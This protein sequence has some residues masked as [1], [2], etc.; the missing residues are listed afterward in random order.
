MD[1]AGPV[2]GENRR[3]PLGPSGDDHEARETTDDARRDP[4]DHIGCDVKVI[5]RIVNG[6]TWSTGG[7]AAFFTPF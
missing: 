6:R 7:T 4:A 3:L 1:R 2:T 5:N